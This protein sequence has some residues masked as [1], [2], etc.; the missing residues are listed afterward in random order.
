MRF[1]LRQRFAHPVE[2]VEATLLDPAFVARA[3]H[4]PEL[5]APELLDQHQAGAVV[6]RRVRYRFAGELPPGVTAVV[7]PD[8]L[9]WV[10]ESSLDR[11]SHRGQHLIVPDHYRDRLRCSY[12]SQ[13]EPHDRGTERRLHGELTVRFPLVGGKV[14]RAIVSGLVDLAELEAALVDRW[15]QERA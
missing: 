8:R 14:E 13:L 9:T 10:D 4:R 11:A 3:G 6:H 5:G 2:A 15:L 12:T 1:A 7:D